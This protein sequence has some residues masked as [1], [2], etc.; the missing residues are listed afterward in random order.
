M[1]WNMAEAG[2]IA[3]DGNEQP[4]D[5]GEAHLSRILLWSLFVVFC[6]IWF[7]TLGARTLVPTDEG[8]YA[9]IAREMA[10]T[11]DFV[12]P[13]LNGIKYFSKPPLQAWITALAFK[14]FGLGEWQARLWTGL[15]GL[16]GVILVAYAGRRVFNEQVGLAA[17]FVLASSFYW[18]A[19]GHINSLDM[20]LST[21]LTL[22]LCA[23]L[24]A[25][26]ND[27]TPRERRN[28]MLVCWAAM[29]LAVLSKGLVGVVLPGMVLILYALV[30][31]DWPLLKRLHFGPGLLIFLGMAAPWFVLVS[32]RNPEFPRVF[33][34]YEH[35]DR[36][37]SGV[38]RRE[39][40]WHYFIP[41]LLVGILPWLGA[42][43]QSLWHGLRSRA[44]RP[45]RGF[46]PQTMLVVWVVWVFLFFT[47]SRSKLPSY[48]L[49][50]FPA[51]ALL[52]GYYLASASHKAILV[53]AGLF[54]AC[55]AIGLGLVPGLSRRVAN[56]DEIPLY[57]AYAPWIIAAALLGLAGSTLAAWLA[58]R[59]KQ[60]SLVM[61]ATAGFLGSQ[62]L[63]IGYEAFGRYR[64]GLT[65]LPLIKAELAPH[66]PVYAVGGYEDVLPF[67]LGRT[68]V[69]VGDPTGFE[70]G[71]RQEPQLWVPT[72]DDFIRKWIGDRSMGRKAVAIMRPDIFADLE[73]RN[74]PMRVVAHD[75][76]RVIV[77][78]G[79]EQ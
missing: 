6:T 12:T 68:L 1:G 55:C 41:L 56:P 32:L 69:L 42:L 66:T 75:A 5:Q 61:L 4:L 57:H 26:R 64:G 9:E 39:G 50:V 73:G 62:A 3:M 78:N 77:T 43:P 59:R 2:A 35:F 49:P 19:A 20:G 17:G 46:Q 63:L 33:L 38:H 52:I 15:C 60:W 44:H 21:M 40:A 7:Y 45:V 76:R 65:H 67:Y 34:V 48:I 30:S 10:V 54:G 29:A 11:G 14:A 70:S 72:L 25:Q 22:A 36:F 37:T 16:F 47:V 74:V 28:W 58:P 27:A 18:A 24:I 8:R 31:R 53:C 79:V 13:R 71:L 23:L 51:L